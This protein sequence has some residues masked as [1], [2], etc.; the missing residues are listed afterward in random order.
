MA[1]AFERDPRRNIKGRRLGS[2]FGGF[3][4]GS[5]WVHAKVFDRGVT[6]GTS[7][8]SHTTV[9]VP[10]GSPSI[11]PRYSDG[12]V[13]QT[14]PDVAPGAPPA[15]ASRYDEPG[16]SDPRA[17]F[18][19]PRSPGTNHNSLDLRSVSTNSTHVRRTP[20]YAGD[21]GAQ[22]PPAVRHRDTRTSRA[23]FLTAVWASY[24]G[25]PTACIH[26]SALRTA[27]RA[28]W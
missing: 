18:G 16:S 5:P 20:R 19:P 14:S 11:A 12:R 4:T 10:A 27:K 23:R 28:R 1:L 3:G 22:R 9:R 6:A 26:R 2:R 24:G 7:W 17:F 15:S 25:P 8:A 21:A 13:Y